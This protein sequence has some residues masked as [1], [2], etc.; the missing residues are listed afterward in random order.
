M[1]LF[2]AHLVEASRDLAA[3]LLR[4]TSDWGQ[5]LAD[6]GVSATDRQILEARLSE[7]GQA[8]LEASPTLGT[9]T[10]Q[11]LEMKTCAV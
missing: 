5:V 9:L 8:L 10:E 7:L 6:L 3:D 4:R 2:S 1:E 11:L